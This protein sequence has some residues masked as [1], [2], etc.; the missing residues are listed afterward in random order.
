MPSFHRARTETEYVPTLAPDQND[1]ANTE[2]VV[3]DIVGKLIDG[4]GNEL[5]HV[6]NKKII[7]IPFSCSSRC[8]RESVWEVVLTSTGL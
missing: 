7:S 8:P 6:Y 3:G 5:D 4:A 2:K 1:I